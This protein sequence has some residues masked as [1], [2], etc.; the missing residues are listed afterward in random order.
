[1]AYG[2]L[3]SAHVPCLPLEAFITH[4]LLAQGTAHYGNFSIIRYAQPPVSDLRWAPPQ[5]PLINQTVVNDSQTGVVCPQGTAQ[6]GTEKILS[7]TPMSSA[8]AV[9]PPGINGSSSFPALDPYTSDD[10][11]LPDV[12]VPIGVY[13]EVF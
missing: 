1:M 7:P 9:S 4:L 6:W 13:N 12:I 2:K 10:C 5:L 11:L 3:Q 8:K